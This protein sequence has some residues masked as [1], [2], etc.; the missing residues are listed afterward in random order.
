VVINSRC[1]VIAEAGVNH[2]GSLEVAMQLVDG[3]AAA[4]AD[5]IKFQTFTADS[6]VGQGVGKAAYQQQT[7]GGG[8]QWSML[9]Q[10]ELGH[11]EHELLYTR[12]IE[13]GIE[14]MS[15]PF[16]EQALDFLVRL[17][18]K[19]IKVASGE[20]TNKPFLQQIA[21]TGLPII[22]STGMGNMEEIGEAV[23]WI[24]ATRGQRRPDVASESGLSLLHC[25]S[26]YP[27]DC[28]DVNLLA[29]RSMAQQFAVPVGYSDHTAGLLIAPVAVALGASIIEKHFTLDRA[30]PGPDHSASLELPELEAMIAAIRDVESALGD[31]LKAPR[32]SE[33]PVRQLVR[34][35]VAVRTALPAGHILRRTDLT[36][37]RPETGIAPKHIDSVVGRKL[38]R[39]LAGGQVLENSSLL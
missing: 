16:D 9:K 19:R 3:A 6:L 24:A 22:L 1:F 38:A 14:F 33:L 37:L 20:L 36:L 39:A 10:L 2:N 7:T 35:S 4:G 21:A 25:T 15:T 26:N 11:R 29:M 30:M 23:E 32:P 18:V 27:A 5:A 28:K 13:R 34:R 8:D 17:G 12:C 31:G